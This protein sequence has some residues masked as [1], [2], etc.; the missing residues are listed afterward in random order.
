[1]KTREEKKISHP[2]KLYTDGGVISKNPSPYGGTWAWVLVRD[3]QEIKRRSGI[4]DANR[5]VLGF[6][7]CLVTNNQSELFAIVDGLFYLPSGCG[8]FEICSDSSVSLGRVFR[9]SSF[10]NIPGWM[11]TELIR[12]KR[13]FPNW[14]DVSYTLLDGHPTKAHLASGVG[15]RGHPVSKW[16]KLCDDLCRAEAENYWKDKN[17]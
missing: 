2:L 13:K 16:N 11:Q 5:H 14:K 1:M 17:R 4:L 6:D 8:V 3:D 9:G 12:M 7:G 10:N 15:K